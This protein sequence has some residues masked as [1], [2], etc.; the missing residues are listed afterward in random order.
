MSTLAF[1]AKP[2]ALRCSRCGRFVDWAEAQLQTVCG[3]RPKLDLPGV[4]V[5]QAEP[6]H[7]PG[8][9]ALFQRDFG[10]EAVVLAFGC[11]T[12]LD[13]CPMLFAELRGQLA[14]AAAYRLVPDALQVLAL[15][16]DPM[17]QRSG[18]ATRLIAEVEFLARRHG[19]GRLIVSTTNDNLPAL[20]FYQRRGWTIAEVTP[21]AMLPHVSTIAPGFA[22]IPVRDEIRLQKLLT[23]A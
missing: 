15:A 4:E 2:T 11:L 22:G 7:R 8:C 16:T 5:R 12:S 18:V 17:W 1:G 3:C 21:G 13:Q 14:G 23:D 6:E 19:V 20:F 9:L 10:R